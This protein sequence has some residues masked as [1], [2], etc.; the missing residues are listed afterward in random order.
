MSYTET[1]LQKIADA[2]REMDGTSDQIAAEDFADRILE[3]QTGIDTSDATATAADILER[4]TAYAKG[5]KIRGTMEEVAQAVPVI[6]VDSATG[7]ITATA[8][9]KQGFVYAGTKDSNKYL[10][11]QIAATITPST[12]RKVAVPIGRYTTGTVY[13]AGDT[14]LVPENIKAGVTIFGVTGTY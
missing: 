1:Q 9:Q 8:T 4:K 14:N 3:I 5:V 10:E 7:L 12:A 11:K 6:E 2:I 13:V